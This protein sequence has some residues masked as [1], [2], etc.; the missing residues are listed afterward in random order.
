MLLAH[1]RSPMVWD[2]CAGSALN[3]PYSLHQP[4]S[5]RYPREPSQDDR[6]GLG[7]LPGPVR[8]PES[9][10]EICCG[11]KSPAAG[12]LLLR[13]V[14]LLPS[15]LCVDPGPLAPAKQQLPHLCLVR[16]WPHSAPLPAGACAPGYVALWW[17]SW[18]WTYS[19]RF[20]LQGTGL[21]G[22]LPVRHFLQLRTVSP[23][24]SFL[25]PRSGMKYLSDPDQVPGSRE[26]LG[27][28]TSITRV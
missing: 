12:G 16:K 11:G 24:T 19:C 2:H 9:H 27:V 10:G 20:L 22:K 18:V 4:P 3:Q 23:E 7:V 15:L 6:P 17:Q 26:N 8:H 14:G 28:F 13:G 21:L 5:P 25:I 1:H